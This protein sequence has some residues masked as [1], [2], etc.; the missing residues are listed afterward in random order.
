MTT[1]F[2]LALVGLVTSGTTLGLVPGSVGPAAAWTDSAGR[3]TFAR[4]VDGVVQVHTITPDGRTVQQI[5]AGGPS[6]KCDPAM[7]PDGTEIAY[8]AN[9]G[10]F[11]VSPARAVTATTPSPV[12]L[13]PAGS[14]GGSGGRRPTWSPDGNTIVFHVNHGWTY[15]AQDPSTS[16]D[17]WMVQ[18]PSRTAAWGL[19]QRLTQLP[20]HWAAWARYSPDGQWLAFVHRRLD[21]SGATLHEV[22]VMPAPVAGQAV[23][24]DV[25]GWAVTSFSDA[26][27]PSWS[28]SGDRLLFARYDSDTLWVQPLTA[29]TARPSGVP[30]QV[31]SGE[32]GTFSSIP[33]DNTIVYES[34]SRLYKRDLSRGKSTQLTTG[35]MPAW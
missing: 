18:R 35:T 4:S 15:E 11:Y 25:P 31:V 23:A 27:W 16:V 17:L 30:S 3:I 12:D 8:A 10:H 29:A 1:R 2:R 5:T 20:G 7:S 14:I 19:P 33:K 21:A 24:T 34:G 6:R 13:T 9:D 26:S 32:I 22:R 28:P